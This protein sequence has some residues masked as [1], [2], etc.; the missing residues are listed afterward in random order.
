MHQKIQDLLSVVK[1]LR[2]DGAKRI[3]LEVEGIKFYV[4]FGPSPTYTLEE[5][6]GETAKALDEL[7]SD[8]PDGL[9]Y[10]SS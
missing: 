4:S 9:I 1:A 2:A 8:E 10:H 5:M 6:S 7:D 3:E